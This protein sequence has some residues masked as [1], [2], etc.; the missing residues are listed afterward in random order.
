MTITTVGYG[1]MHPV[2]AAGQ[3]IAVVLMITGIGLLGV[4]TATF[5]SYFVEQKTDIEKSELNERLDRIEHM[6]A[7]ALEDRKA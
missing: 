5:A 2:T 7:T 3:G 1:D 4:L 6:L